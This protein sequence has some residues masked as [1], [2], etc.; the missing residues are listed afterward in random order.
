M[1]GFEYQTI[2]LNGKAVKASNGSYESFRK[3]LGCQDEVAKDDDNDDD[4]E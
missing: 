4:I 1:E 3:F 2:K